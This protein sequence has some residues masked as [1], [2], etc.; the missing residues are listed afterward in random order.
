LIGFQRASALMM[1]GDKV[2]ATEA[3]QMGMIYKV[4]S[5][6]TFMQ[7]ALKLASNMA[8][9]PT[10]GLG[11]TK[12]LLNESFFNTY[13]KQLQAEGREQVVAANTYDY[14]EGVNSFL[15]KRKPEFKGK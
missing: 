9:M 1:T 7:D 12:R 14:S 2:S 5:D 10:K 15:E 8:D 3:Q 6:D 11:L 4:F 13:E